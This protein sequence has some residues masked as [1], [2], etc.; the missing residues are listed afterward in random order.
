[1]ANSY[2]IN[3]AATNNNLGDY[4]ITFVTD[5]GSPEAFSA[6]LNGNSLSDSY[7]FTP[8]TDDVVVISSVGWTGNMYVSTLAFN[9]D[10]PVY[11]TD[12]TNSFQCIEFSGT[13]T[14]TK[15]DVTYMNW[16]SIPIQ[17]E[18][19]TTQVSYGVPTENFSQAGILNQLESLT[20]ST[21]TTVINDVNG[22]FLRIIG[23]NANVPYISTYPSFQS[24]L[25]YCFEKDWNNYGLFV[26][27]QNLY[28]GVQNPTHVWKM[29][30]TYDNYNS[31]Y[32]G[33]MVFYDTENSELTITGK[34]I[35]INPDNDQPTGAT[36][37][38]T[39]QANNLS[40][41]Q[42]NTNIYLSQFAYTWS[43]VYTDPQ[44]NNHNYAKLSADIADNDV[45]A[46]IVRD[47]LAGFAFGFIRSKTIDAATGNQY[48]ADSSQDWQNCDGLTLF[49]DLQPIAITSPYY[50][51]NSWANV[52]YQNFSNVYSFAFTDFIPAINPQLLVNT[53][54]TLLV[55]I[56]N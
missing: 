15:P 56:L 35:F 21:K 55:T 11:T 10:T 45:F 46:A 1:M 40:M 28:D 42:M 12:T 6:T 25:E 54:D 26:N 44:G 5:P 39:I 47:F 37:T 24:Y 3:F 7:S 34:T 51:Y 17:I 2:T 53:G 33:G 32:N 36:S 9:A 19:T 23:P 8:T 13:D 16:Y 43:M 22:N 18:N 30:Q 27:L 14:F 52:I 49:D 31:N 4:N 29:R 50:Y 41:D 20:S 48:G 38:Y